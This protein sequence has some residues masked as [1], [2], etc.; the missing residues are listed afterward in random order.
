MADAL[1]TSGE[2][3][4]IFG[5]PS[6]GAMPAG[7]SGISI[8]TRTLQAGDAFFAISGD[9]TDGHNYLTQAFAAGAALAVVSQ[10]F[11]GTAAG[12]LLRVA[13]TLV[14]LTKLAEAAR[15]RSKAQIIA[16]TGSVGKTGTKEMLR[17][18]LGSLG[19]VHASD[20]SYNNH[21]GVPLSLARL[22]RSADYAVFE[23]GMNHAGE[24]TPLTK[25]VRPHAAIITT[26][27]PVHLE[28]FSGIEAIAE[29][30]AEIFEGLEAGGAAILNRD[31]D[32]FALLAERA[33][34]HGV[35]RIVGFGRNAASEARL[36]ALEAGDSG[37]I[38]EADILGESI[39][40]ELGAPGEHLAMNSLAA[41]AAVKLA[42]G[43]IGRAAAALAEFGAPAGRGA[44]SV[45]RIAGGR[46]LLIDESYNANPASVRAALKVL[47]GIPPHLATRRIAV[48][49]DMLE[50]GEQSDAMHAALAGPVKAAG[51]DR[52]YCCGAHMEALF[53]ALDDALQGGWSEDSDGLKD[54]LPA[55]IRAGDAIMIKGSL[56]SRMGLLVNAIKD[57]FPLLG[58]SA[59]RTAAE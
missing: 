37:S 1:W 16:V 55:A 10:D 39:T 7:V 59:G 41:L 34:A 5:P 52:V 51:I 26:V 35:G 36:I 21:W 6:G 2:L 23:I 47:G 53:D 20:K 19:Q 46:F 45:H 33:T 3:G 14:A 4:E 27:A 30:K 8:D 31:N 13:D 48:L 40:F 44:Q 49:G 32:Q 58:G 12:P 38:V 24:I 50:L 43:A 29:A 54:T 17:L 9:R 22:P 25:L 11:D 18:M 15:A 42:G 57:R 28:F 56:G